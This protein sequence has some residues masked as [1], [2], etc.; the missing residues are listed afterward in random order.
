MILVTA[1]TLIVLYQLLCGHI[2]EVTSLYSP[3]QTSSCWPSWTV[4]LSSLSQ[5]LR[6]HL[7]HWSCLFSKVQSDHHLRPA[8]VH[9]TMLL[10]KVKENL[11]SL[12]LQALI[13]MERY[14]CVILSALAQTDLECVSREVL[15]DILAGTDLYNQA[16]EE[17]RAQHGTTQLRAAVLLRAHHSTV[18]PGLPHR[19][20]HHPAAF[21]VREL[22]VILA[23]HHAHTAAEWLQSGTSAQ[24]CHVNSVKSSSSCGACRQR[25][26]WIWEQLQH[27]KCIPPTLLSVNLQPALQLHLGNTENHHATS[28]SVQCRPASS[29]KDLANQC[30]TYI[31]QTGSVQTGMEPVDSHRDPSQITFPLSQSSQHLSAPPLPLSAVCQQEQS[32]VALLSQLLVSCSDLLVPL[33]SHTEADEQLVPHAKT[34]VSLA[35]RNTDPLSVTATTLSTAGSV[36]LNRLSTDLNQNQNVEGAQADWAELGI[37]TRLE[38]TCR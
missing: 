4:G 32:S 2:S 26:E 5:E 33:V 10:A 17:Q 20:K 21:S 19:K 11:D 23:V 22:T 24:N 7:N 25:S 27:T 15:Q 34:D 12:G 36:E 31:P 3:F 9:Q 16:V 13:L 14:V 35:I 29:S 18:S 38:T 37:I 6:V 28:T 1:P 8:L 30:Q